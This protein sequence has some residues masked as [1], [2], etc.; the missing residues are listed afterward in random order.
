MTT[1]S[2][3]APLHVAVIV[4]SVREGRFGPVIARWFT[5]RLQEYGEFTFDVVDLA[6]HPLPLALPPVPPAVD[7]AMP[8]PDGM[9]DLTRR[10][11]AADAFVVLTPD[12]NRGYPASL[13]SVIDWHYTQWQAKPI[14]FV[15]YSGGSG[16]LLA[17]EQLKQV[18]GELHAHTVRNYVSF[19]RFY[20]LFDEAGTLR[21]PDEA[22]GAAT[23]MLDELSWWATALTEARRA[24]PYTG[25]G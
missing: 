21:E 15:G 8:R 24:R 18:L 4:G 10:L 14:G 1:H 6:D 19:P 20:L 16:G 25:L 9:A 22:N 5:E 7:P 2:A 23:V 17:I 13:K 3:P 11:D 12:Y